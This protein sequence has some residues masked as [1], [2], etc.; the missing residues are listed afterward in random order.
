MNEGLDEK[1][2]MIEGLEEYVGEG[3][4]ETLVNISHT[5]IS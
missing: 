2:G 3:L 4:D 5:S 1:D